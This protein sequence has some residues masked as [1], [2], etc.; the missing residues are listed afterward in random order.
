M[1]TV[2][3]YCRRLPCVLEVKLNSVK[4]DTHQ[5]DPFNAVSK[6]GSVYYYDVEE[7]VGTMKHLH[8]AFK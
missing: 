2:A 1:M 6:E 8:F 5:Q 4:R 7:Y 3:T